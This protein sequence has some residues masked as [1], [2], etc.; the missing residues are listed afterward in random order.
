[1]LELCEGGRIEKTRSR[2]EH[3]GHTWEIDVFS[4]ANTGLV[5]AEIELE[6]EDEAFAR[7]EW[8]GAEVTADHRFKNSQLSVSPYDASWDLPKR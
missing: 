1:M 7:P 6:S 4:G 3:E 2:V 5:V 8:L